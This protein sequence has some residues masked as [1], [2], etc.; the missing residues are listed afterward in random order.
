MTKI[1]DSTEWLSLK[2]HFEEIKNVH[3]RELFDND[4]TRFEKF[5]LTLDD[6]LVD[7]SK[8]RITDKT[9]TL[10]NSLAR[11]VN[12]EKQRDE[13]F[14]GEKIN[15]TEDRSALHTA[16]R[17]QDEKPI[18]VDGLDVKP[19][20]QKVMNQVKKF[21]ELINQ[22][23]WLGFSGK[24]INTIVNI[25]IGGSDLGPAMV[26]KAL[27]PYA[28]KNLNI[29]FVSN[30][31]GADLA[32][33]LEQCNPESTLFIVASKTFTTQ[34]TMTNAFSAR[35]WLLKHANKDLNAISKHFVALQKVCH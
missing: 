32:L 23:S 4:S 3:M 35:D 16:L 21:S 29:H 22:G 24:K 14:F 17:S 2:K 34:E 31:D 6:F 19:S 27:K 5:H 20:I 11:K 7:F 28:N 30:V 8:N 1:I 15:N 10:L 33:T 13:Q 18:Y 9:S 25:G 26:C 12:I